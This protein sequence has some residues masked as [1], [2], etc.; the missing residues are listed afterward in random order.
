MN[1]RELELAEALMWMVHYH[2]P[3]ARSWVA[4][5]RAYDRLVR[6]G[7]LKDD[8]LLWG[9]LEAAKRWCGAAESVA[10][11]K[12]LAEKWIGP[13]FYDINMWP[14]MTRRPETRCW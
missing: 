14:I 4:D 6:I 8:R 5:T 10:H 13:P 3:D 12:G 7:L 11:A 9:Q 1:R 2:V